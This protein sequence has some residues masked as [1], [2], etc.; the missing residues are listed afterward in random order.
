MDVGRA[1][2][3]SPGS[4]PCGSGR[5]DRTNTPAACGERSLLGRAAMIARAE[6]FT[7][8]RALADERPVS[9]PERS[10]ILK[11]R[12]ARVRAAIEGLPAPYRTAVRL[13]D[14]EG[15]THEEIAAIPKCPVGTVKSRLHRGRCAL[16]D[17][18]GP[19]V[20]GT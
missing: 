1:G 2:M 8:L 17:T 9:N 14:V 3:F 6:V 18:L 20:E 15:F 19:F 13:H 16:R 10:F 4:Q 11:P 5:D 7:F 12:R